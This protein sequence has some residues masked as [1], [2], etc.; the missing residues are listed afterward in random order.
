MLTSDE[1]EAALDSAGLV[2][3]CSDWALHEPGEVDQTGTI[4]GVRNCYMVGT[5]GSVTWYAYQDE[6]DFSSDPAKCLTIEQFEQSSELDG[7]DLSEFGIDSLLGSNFILTAY[8]DEEVTLSNGFT[9]NRRPFT[10]AEWG[11][12]QDALGGGQLIR[13]DEFEC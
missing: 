4:D 8:A 3:D 7:I 1:I 2:R 5:P 11:T 9:L 13:L 12:I 10:E 6:A